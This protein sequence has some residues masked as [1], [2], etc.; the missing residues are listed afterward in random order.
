M[1]CTG[2]PTAGKVLL[3]GK[4]EDGTESSTLVF[5]LWKMTTNLTCSDET[6]YDSAQVPPSCDIPIEK[7]DR[8]NRK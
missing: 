7:A 6:W 8:V 3:C 5:W 1:L 4:S 2:A